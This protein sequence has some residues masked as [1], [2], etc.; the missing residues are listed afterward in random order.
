MNKPI[1]LRLE[2]TVPDYM[3]GKEDYIKL[4]DHFTLMAHFIELET[5]D[6]WKPGKKELLFQDY[7]N[8]F[9]YM[10][11]KDADESFEG[12][13]ANG[14]SDA[15]G[16]IRSLVDYLPK[17]GIDLVERFKTLS[18]DPETGLPPAFGVDSGEHYYDKE[19]TGNN[20]NNE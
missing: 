12:A 13:L 5:D 2:F 15:Y 19:K 8:R 1:V 6:Y 9:L 14:I 11:T 17:L 3:M 20:G 16:K 10:A 4:S 7:D 18:V